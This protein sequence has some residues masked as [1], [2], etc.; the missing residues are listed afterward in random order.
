MSSERMF[1]V[2]TAEDFY[3]MLV[4][5]FDEFMAEQD[6]ARR[7][8]HCAITAYHLY[9]W[10]WADWLKVDHDLWAKLKIR[11]RDSFLDRICQNCVQFKVVQDLANGTKHFGRNQRVKTERISG[12]GMGP[13]G[14][15]P[16]G[17]AYLL[18]DYGEAA[19]EHRWQTAADLLEIVVRFWRD[20]FRDSRPDPGLPASRHHVD[21]P[22]T[23]WLLP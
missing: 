11:D 8:L 4:A 21:Q 10:V 5:D 9:E 23:F 1:D 2:Q 13:Y 20:F 6:S 3:T 14:I 17:Q 19:G 12:Y 16:Y 7:A 22:T 15:G 18:I